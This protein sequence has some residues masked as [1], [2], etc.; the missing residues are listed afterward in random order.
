MRTLTSDK[1]PDVTGNNASSFE[2]KPCLFNLFV[3]VGFTGLLE[4][5]IKM[6]GARTPDI[7]LEIL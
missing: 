4:Y 7:D 2:V 1:P 6:N 5:W 3:S